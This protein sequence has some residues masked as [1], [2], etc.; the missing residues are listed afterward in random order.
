MKV[1]SAVGSSAP[2]SKGF[3]LSQTL[4]CLPISLSL[5]G[6]AQCLVKCC[7]NI[8]IFYFDLVYSLIPQYK[9]EKINY[10]TFLP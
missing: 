9:L 3:A 5:A 4:S 6:Q 7:S 2:D 1:T 8:E 10:S